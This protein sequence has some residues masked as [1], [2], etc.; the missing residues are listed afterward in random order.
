MI[1]RRLAG[2]GGALA[3]AFGLALAMAS[4]ASA[5]HNSVDVR[6]VIGDC[7]ATTFYSAWKKQEHQARGATLVVEAVGE[8]HTV[9]V[10]TEL[11]VGPFESERQI[12]RWRIWGG[13]ERDYD[14]PALS[15]LPA[16][17]EHLDGG[18]SPLDGDAPGVRWHELPVAGCVPP[19]PTPEPTPTVE[20]TPE[21]SPSAEPTVEPSA[22]PSTD[23]SES[24]APGAGGGEELPV[25]GTSWVAPAVGV[26]V[27]AAVVG[28]VLA[29]RFRQKRVTFT[30]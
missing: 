22:N 3:L 7:G 19:S 15:D 23:P 11:T 4:P 21:P 2:A 25:T 1:Y 18:G 13:G 17:L 5:H 8:V 29:L 14:D 27:V 24:P 16:L 12:V 26:G 30:A 28:V 10:G 9:P 6:S 20:P